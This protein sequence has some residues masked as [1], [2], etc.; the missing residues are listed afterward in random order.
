MVE[1]ADPVAD[2]LDVGE[3]VGGEQHGRLAAQVRDQAEDVAA[4]LR[5]EC[6][7]RL[8]EDDDRAADGRARPAIPRRWRMPPE[9]VPARRSAASARSTR[10]SASRSRARARPRRV[11][12]GGR[13]A[14]AA[15]AR[16]SSRRRADPAPGSRGAG[17]RRARR[18][19][20]GMPGDD[21]PAGRRA[22]EA[23]RA[24][25]GM[26]SCRRRWGPSRPNTDPDG[27]LHRQRVEREDAARVALGQAL[28]RGW[29]ARRRPRARGRAARTGISGSGPATAGDVAGA[30][31]AC[32]RTGGTARSGR[33]RHDRRVVRTAPA[34]HRARPRLRRL[35]RAVVAS[36]EEVQDRADHAHEHD[37]DGP[38]ALVAAAD[39]AVVPQQVDHGGSSARAAGAAAARPAAAARA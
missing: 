2:A 38:D 1:D 36:D 7:D 11:R 13:A 39:P 8:V 19:A 18:S 27:H 24:A 37:H 26:S 25:A 16:S 14:A 23:R 17:G 20:T 32:R 3:D 29:R 10:A 4:A 21:R 12:A 5:I 22:G 9:Y 31:I 30:G 33:R 28:D 35:R 15:R 6:A 34:G